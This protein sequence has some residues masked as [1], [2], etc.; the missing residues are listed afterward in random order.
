MSRIWGIALVAL[1]G[2]GGVVTVT[3]DGGNPPDSG[4]PDMGL[5]PP[6]VITKVDLL[7]AIDNSASMGDKQDLLASSMPVLVSRLLNPN[8]VS[9]VIT[10]CTQ[11]SDCASMGPSAACNIYGNGGAGQCFMAGDS[12][13]VTQCKTI[14]SSAPEFPP[15]HDLHVGIVSSSLGG[16][17]SPDVCVVTGSDPTHLDDQGHLLN[18]TVATNGLMDGPPVKN[19]MPLDGSGGNF[20][21]WLPAGF[22]QNAGAPPPDV[23][24][25]SDGQQMQLS[26]D[27]ASLVEGVQQHGCGLEAQL[28]S[29]YHFLVQPDPWQSIDLNAESPPQAQLNGVDATL[30]KMRHDFL[31]PDSLVVVVQVTDEED[32]WSD[33][34]WFGGYGWTSRTQQVPGGPGQGAGPRGTSECDLPVNTNTSP[35]SGGPNDPDCQ[36]CMFPSAMKPQAG[37]PI[38]SDP[39]CQACAGGASTC[40][41]PGWYTPA[42]PSVPIVA[43]DGL[44]ARYSRQFMRRKYGYDNQHNYHRYVDGL[45][46]A[47]VPDR[48]NE[49]H[50]GMN[51]A[52]GDNSQYAPTRNCVNPLY[53]QSLPDGTDTSAGALC[54]LTP[55]PRVASMVFYATLGGVP[56]GLLTDSSGNFKLNLGANDWAAILGANPDYYDFDGLDPHMIQSTAP[57]ASLQ[58]PGSTYSLGTDPVNGREWNTLT[59]AGAIDLQYACTFD[60]PA[61]KDCTAPENANACDCS[62]NAATAPDGPPLCDPATRTNQVKGKVYPQSRYQ[63][64]AKALG[65]QSVVASLCPTNTTGATT[66][67]T[68]GYNGAMNAIVNRLQATLHRQ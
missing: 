62:N 34:L 8:C 22:P 60:L 42:S 61:P 32:S 65:G 23:T 19:A 30:L 66:A 44:N 9:T 57:R 17:G 45:Q 64:V 38:G 14:P 40:P 43:A 41:Q 49:S 47:M 56:N 37:V 68:Y 21:A 28:E 2:C 58:Q 26:S 16:G 7:F 53:A 67:P 10:T 31:R 12:G 24:T 63:L 18:R 36:S 15:V 54:Q 6:L 50:G 25:Y 29:W 33:P 35:P 51:G 3:G 39:N 59:S 27:L 48:N 5:P 55:G 11:A 13:G 46:S 1:V 52:E 20:L 4:A